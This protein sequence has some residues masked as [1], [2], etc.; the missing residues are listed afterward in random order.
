VDVVRSRREVKV[1]QADDIVSNGEIRM[2]TEYSA[3]WLVL[4]SIV[5]LLTFIL[6]C[7]YY[8]SSVT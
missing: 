8:T 3:G 2:F 5:R 7:E 4:D 6:P 1:S